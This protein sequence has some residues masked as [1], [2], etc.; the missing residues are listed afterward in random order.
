MEYLVGCILWVKH[1]TGD[2]K[3]GRAMILCKRDRL[4]GSQDRDRLDPAWWEMGGRGRL[5]QTCT[6]FEDGIFADAGAIVVLRRGGIVV[7]HLG[8]RYVSRG[9]ACH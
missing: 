2:G 8:R 1:D 3:D 7:M 9:L 6:G 4:V 5:S